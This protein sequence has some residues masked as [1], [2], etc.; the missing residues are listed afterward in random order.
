M[1][2]QHSTVGRLQELP[3]IVQVPVSYSETRE[4]VSWSYFSLLYVDIGIL[5][6]GKIVPIVK[7]QDALLRFLVIAE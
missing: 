3:R 7:R 6:T 5:Y 2:K 4:Q 1:K